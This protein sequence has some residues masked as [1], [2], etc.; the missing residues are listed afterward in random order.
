MNATPDA[1]H[2][3]NPVTYLPMYKMVPPSSG[4]Q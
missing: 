4:R 1:E 3:G 2:Y